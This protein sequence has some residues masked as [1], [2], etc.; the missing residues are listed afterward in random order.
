MI[1]R[2]SLSTATVTSVSHATVRSARIVTLVE[3][4][5]LILTHSLLRLFFDQYMAL[6]QIIFS[7]DANIIVLIRLTVVSVV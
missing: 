4:T 7:P 5:A 1:H 2:R 3:L 6:E